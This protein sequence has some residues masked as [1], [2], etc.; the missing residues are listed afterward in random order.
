MSWRVA[1]SLEVLRDQVNARWPHRNKE[2]DGT[3]GDSSHQSRSSDH[4]PWVKDGKMGVVT[5]MDITNDPKSGCDAGAIAEA[6]KQSRDKRIKYIISNRRICAGVDGPSP[7]TWRKYTGSNPHDHHFHLSV[8]SDKALYDST[9]KWSALNSVI[10][11]A[12]APPPPDIPKPVPVVSQPAP[13][14]AGFF[15][16]LVSI[17]AAFGA[18]K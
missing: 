8:R 10:A 17:L 15:L 7:W 16:W 11:E 3:I 14:K 18:K 1:Q 2:N 5:A 6:L 13:Y 12:A 4:N 9:D